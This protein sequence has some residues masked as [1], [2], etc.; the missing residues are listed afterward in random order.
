MDSQHT[1]RTHAEASTPPVWTM[2]WESASRNRRTAVRQLAAVAA[3][4]ALLVLVFAGAAGEQPLAE[5]PAGHVPPAA[6]QPS[7]AIPAGAAGQLTGDPA[8]LVSWLEQ[9]QASTAGAIP[10]AADPAD[11]VHWL[12]QFEQGR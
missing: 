6:Q 11:L 1:R 5:P 10:A 7:T 2:R 4:T 8:D 9:N 3:A 12:E